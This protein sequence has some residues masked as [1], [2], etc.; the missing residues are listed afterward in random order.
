MH[1]HIILTKECNLECTY[2]GG[3]SDTEPKEMQYSIPDLKQFISKDDDPVLEFYGGEPLLRINTM[4]QIMDE[5]PA[6]YVV[7]TNGFFLDKIEQ[8]YIQKFHSI[9]VS[10][11]GTK[12]VTD[13]NRSDGVY[14]RV[15][16]N[17]KLIRER[18]FSGDLV[19]RM[20]VPRG[21]DIYENVRH[22]L[23]LNKP[24]FDHVH[25]QL[26][27]EMF[28]EDAE[29]GLETWIDEYNSGISSLVK[30]WVSEMEQTGKVAG[31]V[32]FIAITDSL[33][34]GNSA[35]LRCGSG[36]DFFAIMP[37]GRISA[38]PVSI[39]YEFSVIG[40]VF[41]DAPSE[42][43]NK[44]CVKEPCTSCDIFTVCGGRC[45]FVNHAQD[46]LMENGYEMI[47]K[48]V[49]HLVTELTSVLPEIKELVDSGVIDSS[50]FESPE[51]NNGCEI[52]P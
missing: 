30:W 33:L 29:P 45:L 46:M 28:W 32:P 13:R 8:E 47:C 15:L 6:R 39:D 35:R 4:Q 31:I 51:L 36:I 21:T 38:C 37:D 1:Y 23:S 11:D 16:H 50:G 14:D 20:T 7:Q 3:G 9:L 48:T 42:L 43:C 44:A 52:I 2:C 19:A 5:I 22:L 24:G 41:T 34:E 49:R 17:I 12:E 25:W 10:I 18:G 27:F 40:S 26:G